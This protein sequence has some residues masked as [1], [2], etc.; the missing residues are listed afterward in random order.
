MNSWWGKDTDQNIG[1][2]LCS[3]VSIVW[4]TR[5]SEFTAVTFSIKYF[6]QLKLLSLVKWFASYLLLIHEHDVIDNG[7]FYSITTPLLTPDLRRC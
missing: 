4:S 5:V 1:V 6:N 3:G 7:K 2:D